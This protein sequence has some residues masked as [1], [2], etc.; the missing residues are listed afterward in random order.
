M[1][2]ARKTRYVKLILLAGITVLSTLSLLLVR[3]KAHANGGYPWS[4]A[5]C[6]ATGQTSGKCPNYEW[7]FS[8]KTKNPSTGN[9][10]YRNCTD[11]VAWKLTSMGV[12]VA[13]VA[14]LGNAGS[15]DDNAPAKGLSVGSTPTVGSVGVDER[16]GHVVFVENVSGSS[17]TISEYN[18]G[19]TGSYGTRSGTP[20]QLGLTKFVSFGL[21]NAK[22][23][24]PS[25]LASA[26]N[27]DGRMILFAIGTDNKIYAKTQKAVNQNDWNPWYMIPAGAKGIAAAP[28]QDGRIGVYYVGNDGAVWYRVQNSINSDSWS[29][30][31]R[32]QANVAG[33]I[34]AVRNPNGIVSVFTVGGDANVYAINQNQPNQNAWRGWYGLQAGA[35]SITA[36]NNADGRTQIFYGGNDGAVWGRY[37]TSASI[38]SW[39]AE[40]RIASNIS[41]ELASVLQASGRIEL[42]AT[43]TDN[44][45]YAISQQTANTNTWNNWYM[46]P[47]GARSLAAN[48]NPDGRG[49]IF[50]VGLDRAVYTRSH[51][52]VSFPFWIDE[53]KLDAYVNY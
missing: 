19:S 23:F 52:S 28:N 24:K 1:R 10:Y 50:H 17:I 30:E 3:G 7:S 43:G 21:S 25:S 45:N 36:V 47:A 2:E 27:A 49:Q 15:W 35:K 8:G 16:Y 34:A 20:N 31:Q 44:N 41:G 39:S 29:A 37:R 32:I 46:I 22:A 4:G 48:K 9:Y 12:A 26:T 11:Y 33:P 51:R 53:T 5:V 13:R 18:W 42:F 38:D 14:G 40:F 6:V